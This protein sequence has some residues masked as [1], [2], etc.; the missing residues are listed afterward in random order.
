M[1]TTHNHLKILSQG[2]RFVNSFK[3]KDIYIYYLYK[4]L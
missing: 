2:K 1:H 4:K 3:K